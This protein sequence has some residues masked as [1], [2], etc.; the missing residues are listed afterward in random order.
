MEISLT[1]GIGKWV[2]SVDDVTR[3]AHRQRTSM[4]TTLPQSA[5]WSPYAKGCY[6]VLGSYSTCFML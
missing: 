2:E 5:S 6:G 1:K 4:H 3:Q